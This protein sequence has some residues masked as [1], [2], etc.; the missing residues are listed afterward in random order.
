LEYADV[1]NASVLIE[2]QNKQHSGDALAHLA[3]QLDMVG[4]VF[5]ILDTSTSAILDW[6]SFENR[7]EPSNQDLQVYHGPV[8]V[9]ASE[10]QNRLVLSALDEGCV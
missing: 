6:T 4:K 9:L 1:N 8:R 3:G 5:G 10:R 7:I 2:V